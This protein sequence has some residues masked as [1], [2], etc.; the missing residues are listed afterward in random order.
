MKRKRNPLDAFGPRLT[1]RSFFWQRGL[2]GKAQAGQVPAGDP[3]MGVDNELSGTMLERIW[4]WLHRTF[5]ERQ[6]YIRSD[7]RVQFFTFGPSL[8]AT[9]AGLVLIFLGWV[10]F[11]TVN[12]VFK[13][14]IIAAKDHRFQQMQSA[15]E[16]R[17]ADLQ[18]SYDELNGALAGAEDKFKATA[19]ALTVKQNAIAGFL[20]RKTQVETAIGGRGGDTIDANPAMDQ[21]TA[22]DSVGFSGTLPDSEDAPDSSLAVMPGPA[23]AQPRVEKPSKSSLLN[24]AWLRIGKLAS[25]LLDRHTPSPLAVRAAYA[26]HPAFQKLVEQT[27][28]VAVL[29]NSET[30]LMSRAEVV[31]DGD[32]GL[33]RSAVKR[34]GINPDQFL[35]KAAASEGVGGPEIP[36]DQVHIEG[37]SDA[38]F[39]QEYL[40]AAAILG[41][42]D[43]L[44]SE[45]SHIPFTTPVAGAAFDRSSGFGAR[46]DPFTGRYAFHPGVDFAGPWGA[47]VTATAPGTVIFAGV[48][49]GYGNMVEIDHGFGVHTRYGH[50]SRITVAIGAKVGKGA[51][52]GRLGSTGRSTGPHVH[53]EVWY[54]NVVRNPSN[55]IEAG[56][57]VL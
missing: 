2:I 55:F 35:H 10:A 39:N 18:I 33:L 3:V 49:G 13:D 6:I 26:Q 11:A 4:A 48:R 45:M 34:T 57:H 40:R 51:V 44:S 21:G 25:A 15:Y 22:S 27:A 12:V 46:V 1:A 19:D 9:L 43:T 30:S 53:Y 52:V 50:L 7:G 41:E 28:R 54:D 32:V 5:P 47:A 24:N 56:H 29:G 20:S 17:L 14:R 16:N 36:L 31:L 42:L 23:M 8:Q 37:I 38:G